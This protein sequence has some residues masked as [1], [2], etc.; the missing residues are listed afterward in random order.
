MPQNPPGWFVNP[1]PQPGGYHFATL[2]GLYVG[3]DGGTYR[4]SRRARSVST[5]D[6]A[7]V[8]RDFATGPVS[9]DVSESATDAP[10]SLRDHEVRLA[11]SLGQALGGCYPP[12]PLTMTGVQEAWQHLKN[13][14][15]DI[16]KVGKSFQDIPPNATTKQVMDIQN[17]NTAVAAEMTFRGKKLVDAVSG[18]PTA[19]LTQ[20]VFDLLKAS[21]DH[22]SWTQAVQLITRHLVDVEPGLW[23]ELSVGALARWLNSL[24][25]EEATG[26]LDNM[27]SISVLGSRSSGTA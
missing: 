6:L 26:Y 2:D 23:E 11:A 7:R 19:F 1:S 25:R 13:G 3:V 16:W 22:M 14:Y 17:H 10:G 20:I 15:I 4:V 18:L 5:S 12:V 8:R 24:V 9:A 21:Q 27:P